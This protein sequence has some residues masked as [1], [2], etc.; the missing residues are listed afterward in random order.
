M[1]QSTLAREWKLLYGA[2]MLEAHGRRL[3]NRI[4]RATIAM[5]A[6][7]KELEGISST[8][9]ETAEL[10]SALSYLSRVA[11]CLASSQGRRHKTPIFHRKGS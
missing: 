5:Q 6:R 7:L 8:S 10:Y 1:S 11:A 4:D 9:L 2:A 3:R